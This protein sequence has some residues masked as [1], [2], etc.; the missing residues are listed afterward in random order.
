MTNPVKEAMRPVHVINKSKTFFDALTMMIQE[1]TNSL[2]VVDDEGK[3]AGMLNTGKLIE[4][5]V[6][7]YLEDDLIAAHF[8][9]EEIFIQDVKKAKDSKIEKFMI[10]DP[11]K[12]HFNASLMEVAII[13]ISAKQLRIPVVDENDKPVGII[14]RT[15]LKKAFGQILGIAEKA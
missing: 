3:L 13:A 7:D 11:Q 4:E 15:E 14:T 9:G 8:A 12:V 5:V 10:S 6:P 2:V 1:K